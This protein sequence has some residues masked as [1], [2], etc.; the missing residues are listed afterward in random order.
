ME[1]FNKTVKNEAWNWGGTKQD[2]EKFVN[3][4]MVKN[5]K[6]REATEQALIAAADAVREE[7]LASYQEEYE[8]IQ[9]IIDNEA[10]PLDLGEL[11]AM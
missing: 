10:E 4:Q 5:R 8:N 7:V 2:A 9:D 11:K 1:N 6:S 3:Q